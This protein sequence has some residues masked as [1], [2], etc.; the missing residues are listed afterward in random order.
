MNKTKAGKAD[1]H[2]VIRKILNAAIKPLKAWQIQMQILIET[3]KRYSES[4][5][6][7]RLREMADIKCNLTD[8]TY[9]IT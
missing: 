1:L 3:G 4:A 2:F 5:V 9:D 6:T 7:A 8:Y